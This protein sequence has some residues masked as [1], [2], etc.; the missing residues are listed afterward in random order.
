MLNLS[1]TA[2][3]RGEVPIVGEISPD[4]AIWQGT[5]LALAEPLR[6]ELRAHSVGEGILVRGRMQT[7]LAL[8]CRRCLTPVEQQ[9]DVDVD[10]LYEPMADEDEEAALSGEVYPLPPRGDQIDIRP[11]LREQL[12]LRVPDYVVCDEGCRGLCPKCGTDLNRETCSCV[13]AA[14]PSPWDALTKL[15]FD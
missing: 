7:R 6:V 2:V 12:L 9:V 5:E 14:D 10:L 11:A 3:S 4:D 8:E 1:L 13:P 15:K